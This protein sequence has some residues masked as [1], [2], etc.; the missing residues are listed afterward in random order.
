VDSFIPEL[1]HWIEKNCNGLSSKKKTLQSDSWIQ[2]HEMMARSTFS[3]EENFFDEIIWITWKSKQILEIWPL[4]NSLSEK[5]VWE[6]GPKIDPATGVRFGSPG[7]LT[8]IHF[9]TLLQSSTC[10][11]KTNAKATR[12]SKLQIG[13]K[14]ILRLILKTFNL[15]PGIPRFS[16]DSSVIT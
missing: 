13:W 16:M 12:N 6:S 10:R 5:W 7:F 8:K 15:V 2:I 3:A 14:G 11:Y 1:E 9:Y 4:L